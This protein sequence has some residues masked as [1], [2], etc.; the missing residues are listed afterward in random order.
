[1][2]RQHL[3][4]VAI[5]TLFLAACQPEPAC[6]ATLGS[7]Q[8][9]TP[10]ELMELP[11]PSEVYHGPTEVEIAGRMMRVDQ[12]ITGPLCRGT[13]KGMVYVACDV[14][15]LEWEEEPLFLKDCDLTIEPATVVYVAA[16][17][18]APYYNGCSCHTGTNP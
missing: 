10:S 6:P 2:N 12:V 18:D 8:Y 4:F 5:I 1:M 3:L 13:W 17:N 15:A 7:P 9:L 16:H 11:P 14:Q